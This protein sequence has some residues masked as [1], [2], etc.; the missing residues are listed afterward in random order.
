MK[1]LIQNRYDTLN[2]L[3]QDITGKT[4]FIHA[5]DTAKHKAKI[6]PEGDVLDL[7]LR[8]S[9]EQNIDVGLTSVDHTGNNAL[10]FACFQNNIRTVRTL[11]KNYKIEDVAHLNQ[12]GVSCFDEAVDTGQVQLVRLLLEFDKFNPGAINVNG[13]SQMGRTPLN[14]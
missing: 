5:A 2:F 3:K 11:L 14:R 10:M 1:Y 4:A 13:R 12:N 9:K 6:P 7:L 8:F